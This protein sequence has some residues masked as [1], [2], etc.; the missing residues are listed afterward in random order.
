MVI[1]GLGPGCCGPGASSRAT[2]LESAPSR[3]ASSSA[4]AANT[5]AGAAPL[6]TRVAIR[7]SAACSSARPPRALSAATAWRPILVMSQPA[8]TA[9]AVSRARADNAVAWILCRGGRKDQSYAP[10]VTTPT[11]S[12]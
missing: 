9:I 5:S 3:F 8:V 4:T 6:A 10:V 12:A 2:R 7:R 11:G 1:H